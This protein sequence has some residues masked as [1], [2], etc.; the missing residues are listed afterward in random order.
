MQVLEHWDP[1]NLPRG[2]NRALITLAL[3]AVLWTLV[4]QGRE[5]PLPLAF[6]T[7]V[8]LGHYFGS[9]VGAP[10]IEGERAPLYLPRG[11]IRLLIV[12]GFGTVAYFLWKDGRIK[13]SIEDRTSAI[14]FLMAALFAGYVVRVL[15]EIL[16]RGKMTSRRRLFENV[17][18]VVALAA[19]ALFAIYC[20][21]QPQGVE[22][23]NLALVSIPL[24]VFYFGSR[25]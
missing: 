8:I 10:A 11:S 18:A 23:Q 12:L 20:S 25:R 24:I 14:L 1:L 21:T 16:S 19:T 5:V 17:K 6:V 22:G 4:L 9:R 3:L 13:L 15:A 2:S 7:L